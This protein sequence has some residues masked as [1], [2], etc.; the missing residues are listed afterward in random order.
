MFQCHRI[1]SHGKGN[2]DTKK[3]NVRTKPTTHHADARIGICF[4]YFL[5][6]LVFP[7]PPTPREKKERTGPTTQTLELAKAY[8]G[9]WE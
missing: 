6:H 8:K 9:Y 3:E 5:W 1:L 7:T 4:P 2:H